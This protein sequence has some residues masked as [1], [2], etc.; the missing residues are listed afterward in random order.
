MQIVKGTVAVVTGAGSGIGRALALALA[1]E[2]CALALADKDAHAVAVTAGDAKRAGAGT[3]SSHAVDV[4]DLAA[5]TR[6][7]DEV[8]KAH[9][10]AQ[11]LIS[12]AGAALGGAFEALAID[13]MRRLMDVDFWG[14]VYGARLFLPLLRTERQAHIVT[15][16]GIFGIVAVAGRSADAASAFALRGFSEA[17][18]HELGRGA[19]RVTTVHPG[20]IKTDLARSARLPAK[21]DAGR[22]ERFDRMAR[23]TPAR[24]AERILSGIRRDRQRIIIGPDARLLAALARL[25]PVRYGRVLDLL[26]PVRKTRGNAGL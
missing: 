3:V 10:R 11:L 23:T 8:K 13:D 22:R 25:L 4:A 1:R 2:G 5:M 19:I 21:I 7:R 17:L 14:A 15:I 18:R 12:H 20:G 6:F 16:S 24:A 26:F 9:G